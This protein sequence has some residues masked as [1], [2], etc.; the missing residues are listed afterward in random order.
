MS[1]PPDRVLATYR[2]A[3]RGRPSPRPA[4]G[5][6]DAESAG[7]APGAGDR[8]DALARARA[9]AR[10][11]T[12]EVPEGVATEAV[13]EL[14][15]GRVE[16]LEPAPE[17]GWEAVVS[18]APE[19]L[20]GGLPQL[21]NVIHGNISLLP[22]V[23]LMDLALPDRVLAHLPGPRFGIR[24]IR[25]AVGGEAGGA[26]GRP[27]VAAAIKPVGLSTEELAGLAAGFARAGVDVVKDDHSLADQRFSGFR[28]R[29][30]AVAE[31]IARVNRGREAS[32]LYFVNVT[33]PVEGMAE[34]AAWAREAGCGGV[35]VSPG[36][37]GLD[38]VRAL[39]E[40]GCGLPVMSHPSRADVGPERD[41]GVAPEIHFGILHRLIGADAV[42]YVNAGGRFA[43]SVETCQAVNARLRAPLGSLRPA[44]PVPAGGVDADEAPRWFRAYGSDTML[45]IGG[46]LLKER[47]MEGAA[48]RLVERARAV[49]ASGGADPAREEG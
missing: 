46:S 44:F 15:L 37:V 20:D 2:L 22:G 19:I 30:A 41:T 8:A 36:L 29:A 35:L 14:L 6:R 33:G 49:G 10:E 11:S 16:S 7:R 18:H 25:E 1:F 38:A 13:E 47:D 40:G 5:R 32:T 31:A 23:R 24:G 42:V 3:P 39:V 43:W 26:R 9:V 27:L 12:L 48:R 21:L 34:R 17:G 28:E 45:L 4:V